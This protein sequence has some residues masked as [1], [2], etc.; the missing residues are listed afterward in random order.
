MRSAGNVRS[1]GGFPLLLLVSPPRK[2]TPLGPVH[3]M[4]SLLLQ[5][6]FNLARLTASGSLTCSVIAWAGPPTESQMTKQDEHREPYQSPY[7]LESYSLEQSIVFR[8]FHTSLPCDGRCIDDL[9]SW[10]RTYT[11]SVGQRLVWPTLPV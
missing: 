11:G 7:Q 3:L 6:S 1:A 5:S 10:F 2:S 9:G 8:S 4:L